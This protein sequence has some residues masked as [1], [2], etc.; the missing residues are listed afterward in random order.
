MVR[1]LKYSTHLKSSFHCRTS[2]SRALEALF[3]GPRAEEL[4]EEAVDPPKRD[5]LAKNR[6]RLFTTVL[7]LRRLKHEFEV[8]LG[9]PAQTTIAI[10]AS[11]KG[12]IQLQAGWVCRVLG[13]NVD[14]AE[15]VE[16][17]LC[18]LGFGYATLDD[19]L[20]VL[21][22]QLWLLYGPNEKTMAAFLESV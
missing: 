20:F 13:N 9:T 21:L 1:F 3:P 11:S 10:D 7:G 17:P 14:E 8:G 5:S 19:K 18:Q 22:W 15:T 6:K 4:K 16:L 12:G 2:L